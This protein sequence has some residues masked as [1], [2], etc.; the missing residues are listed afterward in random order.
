MLPNSPNIKI[1]L[2][3]VSSVIDN[4]G[5]KNIIVSSSKDVIGCSFSI[6]SKE[7]Y[8]SLSRKSKITYAIKIQSILY[9]NEKYAIVNDS[10][11][12][13]DRTF[14]YSSFIE[15]YLIETNIKTEDL[16]F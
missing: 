1:K 9:N 5:N 14:Q 11:Y 7:H 12:L 4:I 8:E 15:L 2:L 16:V 3:K 6:N 10:L 13:I